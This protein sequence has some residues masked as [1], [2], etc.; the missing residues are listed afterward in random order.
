MLISARF[1]F[2]SAIYCNFYSFLGF[3][4]SSMLTCGSFTPGR[5]FDFCSFLV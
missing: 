3:F 2:E 4:Y 5:L 1:E